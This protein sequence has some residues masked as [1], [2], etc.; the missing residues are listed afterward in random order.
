MGY[1]EIIAEL[2]GYFNSVRAIYEFF[3]LHS[4]DRQQAII[5]KINRL[6]GESTARL[7]SPVDLLA[8]NVRYI[9]KRAESMPGSYIT[10][11]KVMTI[12][13]EGQ[14]INCGCVDK[15]DCGREAGQLTQPAPCIITMRAKGELLF[16]IPDCSGNL[17]FSR[18]FPNVSRI[19]IRQ[20]R[21][22]IECYVLG[23]ELTLGD[24]GTLHYEIL[25]NLFLN[26]KEILRADFPEDYK[27]RLIYLLFGDIAGLTV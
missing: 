23:K 21:N 24:I 5:S 11:K 3:L 10:S 1:R 18:S 25:F 14:H 7:W 17:T 22:V 12:S 4:T 2:A 27:R 15:L 13:L 16:F 8:I 6:I 26:L 20:G 9:E 19:N